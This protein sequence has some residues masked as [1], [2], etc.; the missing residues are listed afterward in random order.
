MS[1]QWWKFPVQPRQ[2]QTWVLPLCKL[3]PTHPRLLQN[4]TGTHVGELICMPHLVSRAL[5]VPLYPGPSSGT[6][7]GSPLLL[8]STPLLRLGVSQPWAP[9][10]SGSN[11]TPPHGR[12][13]EVWK[14]LEPSSGHPCALE[15]D[16][17]LMLD[18][19]NSTVAFLN[20]WPGLDLDLISQNP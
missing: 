15:S 8:C 17:F 7:P 3:C 12:C 4:G 19:S 14:L 13:W 2:N 18:I 5:L 1:S 20:C 9:F 6:W 16:R 11:N 10:P